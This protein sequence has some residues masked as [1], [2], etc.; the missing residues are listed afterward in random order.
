M[1]IADRL[2]E[3]GVELPPATVPLAVYRPAVRTG[4]LIFVSGQVAL[5][6]GAVMTPGHLG[7][8]V[9]VEEGYAAARQCAINGLAAVLALNGTLDRLRLIRTVGYVS[10]AP[11]FV[12]A[13]GV[14]N[15]AS[16]LLR[17][18]FGE[19]LGIGTRTAIGIASLPVNSPVE[20]ELQFEVIQ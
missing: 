20:V 9:T 13:P 10:S 8:E 17:D 11:D 14:V 12:N 15:G 6:D 5:K 19:D 2:K 7:A 1:A 3:L 16:E 4:N 18:I